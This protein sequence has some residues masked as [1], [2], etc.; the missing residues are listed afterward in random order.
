MARRKEAP[1]IEFA[2]VYGAET[3][4][5]GAVG[6]EHLHNEDGVVSHYLDVL[7]DSEDAVDE[8]Y[9]QF[10]DLHGL[11]DDSSLGANSSGGRSSF[12][13]SSK[14]WNSPW[15]PAGPKPV[16][17]QRRDLENDPDVS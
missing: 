16:N 1:D 3:K 9:R 10:D 13:F 11:G 17:R 12:G 8:V 15:N 14:T 4:N 7:G 6:I 2:R 5:G